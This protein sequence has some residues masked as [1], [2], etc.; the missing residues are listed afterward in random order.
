M[1]KHKILLIFVNFIRYCT[2]VIKEFIRT[3]CTLHAASLSFKSLLAIIPFLMAS[4]FIISSLPIFDQWQE[5][6]QTFILNTAIPNVNSE[7]IIKYINQLTLDR[8]ALPITAAFGLFIVITLM[9]RTIEMVLNNIWE[10]EKQRPIIRALSTYL[11]VIIISPLLLLAGMTVTTYILTLQ[12]V[13]QFSLGYAVDLLAF[14][15]MLFNIIAF[16]CVQWLLPYK[17]IP[18][19]HVIVGAIFFGITF[20]LLKELFGLYVSHLPSYQMIYGAMSIVPIFMLWVI[21]VWQLFLFSAIV[22]K[23]LSHW[24]IKKEI[25]DEVTLPG[26]A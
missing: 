13:D 15:P 22:I 9:L 21:F 20:D 18:F 6:F 25:D 2:W 11:I 19:K 10:V 26:Q 5:K 7:V 24:H 1:L 3:Q 17:K 23:G 4:L 12:W 8:N 16:I 14:L